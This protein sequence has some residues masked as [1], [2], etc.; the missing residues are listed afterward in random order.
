MKIQNIS[1]YIKY[2]CNKKQFKNSEVSSNKKYDVI[3]IK[4]GNS[5]KNVDKCEIEKVKKKIVSDINEETG[6]EK[7]CSLKRSIKNNTYK[8]DADEL[9]NKLLDK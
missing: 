3:Q 9:A 2:S 4:K 8:I 6:S 1:S 5:E 7:I